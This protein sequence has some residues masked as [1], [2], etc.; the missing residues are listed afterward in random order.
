MK[1][2][3]KW[4]RE[5]EDKV[6][7][8]SALLKHEQ[9][10]RRREVRA[11]EREVRHLANALFRKSEEIRT[12]K[13]VVNQ[14]WKLCRERMAAVGLDVRGEPLKKTNG[15]SE[16]KHPIMVNG[17]EVGHWTEADGPVTFVSLLF[18]TKIEDRPL[19]QLPVQLTSEGESIEK[20]LSKSK[21]NGGR[22]G[23]AA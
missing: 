4:I 15:F 9:L 17:H 11:R 3:T 5:L 22:R 14:T 18:G 2:S 8:L 12:C 7:E 13:A 21:G 16:K 19:D 20:M 10:G 23:G 6:I 1:D